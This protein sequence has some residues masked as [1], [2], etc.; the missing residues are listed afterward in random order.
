M[1]K[2]NVGGTRYATSQATIDDCKDL[3]AHVYAHQYQKDDIFVDRDPVVFGKMLKLLRG[4]DCMDY[5]LD[6]DVL[7]ELVYW[8]HEM[9]NI[10]VPDWLKAQ[11]LTV[12]TLDPQQ[13]ELFDQTHGLLTLDAINRMKT[14]KLIDSAL[15]VTVC[16]AV[17]ALQGWIESG[18]V[19]NR[20]IRLAVLRYQFDAHFLNGSRLFS[21]KK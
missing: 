12:H 1:I 6:N 7:C 17:G 2:L 4:Y 15:S 21:L 8:N 13:T 11:P 18:W 9:V 14:L 20:Q 16:K 19:E 3:S 5:R 10:E